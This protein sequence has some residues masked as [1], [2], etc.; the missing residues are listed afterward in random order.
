MTPTIK[1]LP[2]AYSMAA[3]RKHAARIKE[4]TGVTLEQL[5]TPSK[6]QFIVKARWQLWAD[7]L[8]LEGW[9]SWR[10]AHRFDMDHTT[11][12][13]GLRKWATE[14]Y[15]TPPKATLAEIREAHY[16]A[17]MGRAA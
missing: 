3:V 11:I 13:Y 1:Y 14:R 16:A 15:G 9:T 6:K 12:L 2:P 7:L 8:L 5:C 4:E 10:M 17:Q